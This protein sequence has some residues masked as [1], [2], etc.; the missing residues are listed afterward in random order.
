[1]SF[2]SFFFGL[3]VCLFEEGMG[4]VYREVV[5]TG[6]YGFEWFYLPMRKFTLGK[7]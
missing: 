4:G 3:F 5:W 2:F 7:I 6:F 1:M